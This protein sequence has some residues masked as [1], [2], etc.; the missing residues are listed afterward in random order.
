MADDFGVQSDDIMISGKRMHQQ[1]TPAKETSNDHG[2]QLAELIVNI[3]QN[4]SKKVKTED[5]ESSWNNMKQLNYATWAIGLWQVMMIILYATVGGPQ[6]LDPLT[7]PG[8]AT[9]GYNMFIGVEVMMFIGFGYLMTFL[10]LY[11]LGALGFTMIVTAIGLQWAV[12]TESFFNQIWNNTHDWYNVPLNIYALLDALYAVSAVLI[13]FGAVI[14]KI[15]PFQLV[16]MTII[17]LILHSFNYKILMQ[18]VLNVADMGGTYV[19]HMFGAYFGL[20]LSFQLGKP[21]NM[22]EMGAIPDIFSLIGTLFLWIYWPS[23]VAGAA[24]ADSDQQ[25]RA[26]V[27][28]ILALSSGNMAA[29]W[30]SSVLS[31]NKKYRPVDIQNATLAGGVA[32]GCT[33]NLTMSGFSAVMIGIT[34]SLVSTFGYNVIQPLLEEKFGLHDTCGIHNLHAMPSVIGALASVILAGYK[35]SDNKRHDMDIYGD[36]YAGQWWRQLVGIF[37][38]ISCAVVTGSFV[39]RLLVYLQ[40]KTEEEDSFSDARWWEVATDFGSNLY[41]ELGSIL[42]NVEKSEHINVS[43]HLDI[44]KAVLDKSSHGG[45]R[46]NPGDVLTSSNHPYSSSVVQAIV[47][48]LSSHGRESPVDKRN[49]GSAVNALDEV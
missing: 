46:K 44:D 30:A 9:Q 19:D 22:P 3:F 42:K 14:G 36:T 37:L 2:S 21:K 39:G 7:A 5:E 25:A 15:S 4:T 16:V 47:S 24:V 48:G 31:P 13:T 33:A 23:F 49:N 18:G 8:T 10:K 40:S 20:A 35:F 11:G 38:C 28:T 26:L 32:I 12:F 17:E 29:F 45:R 34:A 27:N 1:Y 6:E 41:S 43:E